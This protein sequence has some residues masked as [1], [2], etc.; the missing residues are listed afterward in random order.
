[1]DVQCVSPLQLLDDS[2]CHGVSGSEV[3]GS[4]G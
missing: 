1:M 4:S 3:D 2:L